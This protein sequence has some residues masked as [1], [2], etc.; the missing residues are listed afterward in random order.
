M[1]LSDIEK[2]S[3]DSLATESS[4]L[5]LD[6]PSTAASLCDFETDN[7][8]E[9]TESPPIQKSESN[10]SIDLC[11][12]DNE[13]SAC[14]VCEKRFKSKSYMNKHLRSVHTGMCHSIP[15]QFIL[16]FK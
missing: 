13:I 10:T 12:A 14:I 16:F 5:A 3:R 9:S 1:D 8:L 15:L 6:Y 7:G 2:N 4:N 11:G